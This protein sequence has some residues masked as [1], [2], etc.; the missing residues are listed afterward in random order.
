[1]PAAPGVPDKT[2]LSD[3]AIPGGSFPLETEKE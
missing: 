1:V 3:K 2:P